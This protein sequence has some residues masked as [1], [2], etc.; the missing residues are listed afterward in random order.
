MAKGN[1]LEATYATTLTRI[2]AQKGGRS[3]L[4]MEALMWVSNSERPLHTSELCHALGVKIGSPDLN[5]ENIPA[6]KTLLASSL[7]LITVEASSSTTRLVHFSLQEHICN[8][9]G[10]FQSPHSMI[11]E[12]CLTFL[13]FKYVRELSPTLDQ[14]PSMVP[15]VG[16]ASIYWGKHMRRE[17]RGATSPLALQL[18][19]EFERHI[20]SQLLLLHYEKERL[21]WEPHFHVGGGPKGFTGLHGASFF[22]MVEV[23]AALLTMKEYDINA[24]DITGKTAFAWA[25]RGGHEGVIKLLLEQENLN[26]SAADTKDRHMPLLLATKFGHEGIVKLLLKREG[27]DPNATGQYGWT[28]LGSAARSG[29][30]GIVKLLLEREDIDPN[31]TEEDGWTP[32]G[33]AAASGHQ[34]IVKLLL[35][36]EDI[37]PNTTDEDGW[38]PLLS[39]AASGH[40]EIVKLLLE[41]EDIDPNIASKYGWTPLLSAAGRGHQEIVRLLLERGDTDPN[42][43]DEY[44]QTPL[45]CAVRGR[46]EG[47]V[48]LLL[49][50]EDISTHTDGQTPLM[51]AAASGHERVLKL[52]LRRE[53]INPNTT[54]TEYG[55]TPLMLAAMGGHLEVVKLLLEQDVTNPDISD[56]S[57]KTALQLAASS[58]HTQVVELLSPSEPPLPVPVG[59]DKARGDPLPDPSDLPPS[60]SQSIPSVCLS[61]P[62]PPPPPWPFLGTAVRS[63]MIIS[64]FIFLFSLFVGIC[65]SFSIIS[66]LSYLR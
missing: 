32:L 34:E 33:S 14:T 18:L 26:L 59:I 66:L 52:L 60:P 46:H 17:K 19:F 43:A 57:G 9:P 50:R 54:D 64:S 37:D 13:N 38:T 6:I 65:P 35:E 5:V 44:G 31:T 1:H 42:I 8:N 62:Q 12:V 28:P 55:R 63:F 25:A 27:I 21:W 40:Q 53:D 58:G 61:P 15:L 51:W 10:L 39:A 49:E 7:G 47:I 24:V 20:S 16:Y 11:A 3:R 56:L 4:G 29:H 45:G 36:R 48:N 23:V 22:G 30:E 2:K 41:R